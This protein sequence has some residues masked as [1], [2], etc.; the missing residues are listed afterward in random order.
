M[1]LL[2]YGY[3]VFGKVVRGLDVAKK[4]GAMPTSAGGP[5]KEEV[6]V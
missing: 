2:D 4:I 1:N 6:P 5:F 3:C